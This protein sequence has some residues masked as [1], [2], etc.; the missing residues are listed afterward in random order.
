[1]S[2]V[3]NNQAL[4]SFRRSHRIDPERIRRFRNAFYKNGLSFEKSISG[5]P[6]ESH[7]LLLNEFGSLSL[8][9]EGEYDSRQ[10]GATKLLL[11]TISGH[12]IE[13][14]ILRIDSGRTS[15]CISSQVGCAAACQF[16]AT[17]QMKVLQHLSTVEILD[18][19]LVAN[20]I[21]AKENRR[22]RNIVFMGMG[23]PLHNEENVQEAI[24]QLT[25]PQ[26]FNYAQQ[27]LL[28]STVGI[29]EGMLRLAQQFPK[30]NLALSLHS[31]VQEVRDQIIPV[32]R[33][34][35]LTKLK[36]TLLQLNKQQ[37][38]SV[39]IE[40]LMLAGVNDSS[41]DADA[42]IKW[43]NGLNVHLNLIPYN[44]IK[45]SPHLTSSTPKVQQLFA[46]QLRNAGFVV[47]VRY[48]LG[49]DITAACGQLARKVL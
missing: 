34:Y 19:V 21:L 12:L 35:S 18:Q 29:P 7:E 5:L 17:G 39:M 45:E 46:K 43:L 23:E 25:S 13:T 11:R 42:L 3:H 9:L 28:V 16:C 49:E 20:Q 10:D 36:E 41:S 37:Q 14:V 2:S 1:M 24:K 15:L 38:R 4:E 48:S 44:T 26:H 32:S 31:A 27:R 40:Y 8:T 33:K 22:V 47:T 6:E 30:I